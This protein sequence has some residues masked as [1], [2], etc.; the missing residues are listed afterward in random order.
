MSENILVFIGARGGSKGLK[1]KNIKP[2]MGKPLIAHTILTAL[3]WGKAARVIVSTDSLKIA[4]VAKHYGAQ[5]PFLRPA[6]MA[7]DKAPKGPALRHALV[8]CEKIFNER[9]TVVVDL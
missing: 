7:T 1:D 5:V 3:K 8:E 4:N 2:L 6:K 9:Y